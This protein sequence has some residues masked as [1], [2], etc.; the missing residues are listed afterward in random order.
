MSAY[1]KQLTDIEGNDIYPRTITSAIIDPATG[2]SLSDTLNAMAS[3]FGEVGTMSLNSDNPITMS[4][5]GEGVTYVKGDC[6]IVGRVLLFTARVN[7]GDSATAG[8][9]TLSF[10]GMPSGFITGSGIITHESE[11]PA[12][13]TAI[14]FKSRT[15]VITACHIDPTKTGTYSLSGM[16]FFE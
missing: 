8:K 14:V 4:Y 1:I 9:V 12:A 5:S 13:T 11:N 15:E 6:T 10:N 2:A 7:V 3:S 16:F